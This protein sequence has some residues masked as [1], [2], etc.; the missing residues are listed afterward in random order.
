MVGVY[1]L[2]GSMEVVTGKKLLQEWIYIAVGWISIYNKSFCG[3]IN[4][5]LWWYV[6]TLPGSTSGSKISVVFIIVSVGSCKIYIF[7]IYLVGQIIVFP[8][9]ERRTHRS[10]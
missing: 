3:F 9:Y 8:L 4:N 6:M 2:S 1:L 10:L 7:A 5:K